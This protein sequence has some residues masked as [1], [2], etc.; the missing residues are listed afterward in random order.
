MSEY[1]GNLVLAIYCRDCDAQFEINPET[2]ALALVMKTSV[3]EYIETI[4]NS[5][6]RVCK[7][8]ES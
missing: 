8:D 1:T 3:W 2:V 5:T 6:C 4:Q 7:K